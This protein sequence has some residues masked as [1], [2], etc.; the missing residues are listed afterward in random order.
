M[1]GIHE[2]SSLLFRQFL[3]KRQIRSGSI[4]AQDTRFA[5]R[6]NRDIAVAGAAAYA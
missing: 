4:K 2:G 5:Q 6:Q 3:F 1:V